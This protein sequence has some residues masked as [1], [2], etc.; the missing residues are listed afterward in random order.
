MSHPHPFRFGVINERPA[1]RE[2][3]LAQVRQI[4]EWG[5]QTFLI[6]DHVAPD[7][8]GPQFA[9]FVAL[10]LA[11]QATTRLRVGTLVIANDFRHPALLAKEVAT[12]DVLS[13]GR[14]EL[15]LGAGWLQAEYA[16]AGMPYDP[17][18]VRIDRLEESIA[19]LKGL[20][21]EA[22]LHFSGRH[23]QVAGL[24]S[25]PTPIQR[26]HPPLLIGAGHP[27]MLRLAGRAA[28]IVGILTTS[29]ASGR[30]VDDPLARMAGRVAEQVAWVRE[31][32]GARFPALELSLVAT[33]IVT[34]RRRARTEAW[35]RERGWQGIT[36][37]QVWEMPAVLIGSVDQI[38]DDL[39]RWRER[40]G[41]SYIVV[42][43][44]SAGEVAPVVARLAGAMR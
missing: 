13:G 2:P 31:G 26:P 5:Y 16:Q 20:F 30:M 12:L 11:A 21:A 35:I 34:D 19:V 39:R 29:V 6:R 41:F 22:P 24:Q 3:W 36:V 44:Q 40:L 1:A 38:C 37:E 9:P 33:V 10:M 18:G 17:P 8:F 4:E 32:A 23:Y 7:Y 15:G 25:F 43:D 42:A 28:D 27:R 14:C